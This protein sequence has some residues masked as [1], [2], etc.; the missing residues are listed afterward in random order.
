MLLLL[1]AIHGHQNEPHFWTEVWVTMLDQ[2]F[3]NDYEYDYFRNT[4]LQMH[5]GQLQNIPSYG[6]VI[7]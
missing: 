1:G 6:G 5:S 4:I 7:E 2:T 3:C